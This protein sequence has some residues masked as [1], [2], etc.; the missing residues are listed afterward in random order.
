MRLAQCGSSAGADYRRNTVLRWMDTRHG[1]QMSEIRSQLLGR[2]VEMLMPLRFRRDHHQH[3]N[4]FASEPR[5]RAMG[6]GFELYG[7]HL[8]PDEPHVVRSGMPL[9]CPENRASV[10]PGSA[11]PLDAKET[12]TWCKCP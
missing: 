1:G 5:F 4:D 3:R 8:Q 9:R 7:L 10:G 12:A 6:E 2:E 11:G